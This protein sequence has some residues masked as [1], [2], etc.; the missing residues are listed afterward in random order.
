[1]AGVLDL[2]GDEFAEDVDAV[3][4]VGLVFVL[5]NPLD[6]CG[7]DFGGGFAELD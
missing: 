5:F 3:A 2:L 4:K 7:E 1:M 6:A